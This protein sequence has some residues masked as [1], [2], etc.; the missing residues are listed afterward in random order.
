MSQIV[1]QSN[2][3]AAEDFTKIYKSFQDID[4]TAYDFDT[5]KQA[6]VEYVRTQ[7]PED[8]NDYIE[9]SEFIAIIELLAYLGTSLAFRVDLNSRENIMDT[10]QRRESIVR[11]ARLINYQPRRNLA[12]NGLFKVASIRTTQPLTDSVGNSLQ[13]TA[14]FWSDPNNPDWFDQFLTIINN[15]LSPTNP[16]GRPTKSGTIGS[17]PTD[18]YELNNVLGLNVTQPVS[19]RVNGETVPVDVVNPDFVDGETIF[20]RDPDPDAP[21]GMLY[22]NDSLGTSSDNTGFFLYFRQGTLQ[23]QDF[24]YDFPVP[25]RVEDINVDN[26]NQ[27]DVYVQEIDDQGVVINQWEQV[28]SVS[29]S[30]VIF[31]SVNFNERNIFEVITQVNDRISVKYADGNF[32]NTPTGI[33]RYWYRTSIGRNIVIRPEDATGLQITIP[34]VGVDGQTYNL[35]ITFDLL[36]TVANGAATETDEQIKLR[37]P[38]TY[39]TQERM[40]NN[41]DY[42]VFPLLRGN[43]IAKIRAIN[44]THAGHSRYIAVNDP[45]GFHTDL[46]VL[47]DDGALYNDNEEQRS[48]IELT[49]TVESEITDAV[50]FQIEQ[51]AQSTALQ[52]FFDND[53]LSEFLEPSNAGENY[54]ELTGTNGNFWRNLPDKTKND[55]GFLST[56]S[57]SNNPNSSINVSTQANPAYSY[58]E[59]GATLIFQDN[60]TTPTETRNIA[61]RSIVNNGVVGSGFSIG[62]IE[63]G[64]EVIRNYQAVEVF[65]NFND[66]FSASVLADIESRITA[67]VD[68]AL[69][70][71]VGNN[72]D[73]W[74]VLDAAQVDEFA[75]F[76]LNAPG[77]NLIQ[78]AEPGEWLILAK[79][80]SGQGQADSYEFISRGTVTIFESLNQARFFFD[81]DQQVFSAQ[82]G[83]PVQ[84]TIDIVKNVNTDADGQPLDETVSWELSG[85]FIQEDGFQDPAKIEVVAADQDEDGAPDVPAAFRKLVADDDEVIFERFI[86]IDGYERTRPW[87]SGQSDLLGSVTAANIE[88]IIPTTPNATIDEMG[89]GQGS[90]LELALSDADIFI[91]LD[92]AVIDEIVNILNATYST[93]VNLSTF[94]STINSKTLRVGPVGTNIGTPVYRNLVLNGTVVTEEQDP[95]HFGRNGISFNQDTNVPIPDREILVYKWNHVAPADQRI[96]P[97]STNIIDTVLLTNSYNDAVLVWKDERGTAADLPAPPTTEELRVQ[98]GELNQFKSISDEIIYNSGKF[99]ILF[100]P[101]AEP[102][103]R[104]TFKAVKIPTATISD[105]E[106]KTR[107]IDAIDEYFDIDN[108]DF[109]ETF[110]YTELAAF[111][112]TQLSRFLSSVVIVP[113]KEESEFGD[114]FEITSNPDEI[115]LSTAT[116]D[117]V[118]I[119]ANYTDTNLRL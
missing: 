114:L 88:V 89:F 119:V 43:E 56:D 40:V 110:Y 115:F 105:N 85:V 70:Y 37:A 34:Y 51:F 76:Q 45:T 44:R 15:A 97:S 12:A 90:G 112:H 58:I 38:Q 69:G 4:F 62:P 80:N 27:T 106:L 2:L 71:N 82:T 113:E 36:Q 74:Y 18:L 26:I 53:Y 54:F 55:T 59:G 32:G 108:W 95:N 7:Y 104:A 77:G 93:N 20:E 65:P 103:L 57:S 107:I 10:A 46:T 3:F 8:F 98:F 109:G 49:S 118:V 19:I 72:A 41:E 23:K 99:K 116:V 91:F 47:G 86:D 67:R 81:P 78:G 52:T 6:L 31:N 84:D 75:Q 61:V 1:R 21:F 14:V 24:R 30:N 100:G 33:L 48:V 66:S 11:L 5:I 79:F 111:I 42:N 17:I 50:T 117:S 16:F 35:T 83:R 63:L 39:Y 102:E 87:V 28:P 29:G 68:F 13:N 9:S 101:Q 60:A 94:V 25:N 92:Q 73:P 64:A 22:R 96:D